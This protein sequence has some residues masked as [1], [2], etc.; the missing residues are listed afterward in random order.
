[1]DTYDSRTDDYIAR[2]AE[3]AQPVLTHLRQLIHTACPGIRETIKWGFPHFDHKGTVC[4]FAAFKQHCSLTFAKASLLNDED[5]ILERVGRTAMGHFGQI[6][7][8]ADLPPDEVL[9][10]YIR[11]AAELNER[12]VKVARP[13]PETKE[14]EI[15]AYFMSALEQV[16][17]SLEV[18]NRFPYSH[19]KEYVEWVT[20][21]KTET[22][23]EKRL[24]TTVEWLSEGKTRMWKYA[25]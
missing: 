23:R 8:L 6:K 16:P 2:S 14:L 4:S 19:R 13:K 22:T 11:E 20:E 1:M 9:I 17:E 18:F 25:K 15:P 10:R 12:N 21:A 24:A 7:G 3:F 5:G